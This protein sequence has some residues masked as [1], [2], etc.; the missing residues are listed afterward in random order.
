MKIIN[1]PDGIK[2]TSLI[3]ASNLSYVGT[4]SMIPEGKYKERIKELDGFELYLQGDEEMLA[5]RD[6][7]KREVMYI[8]KFIADLITGRFK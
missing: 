4:F 3:K 2:L 1:V 6:K 7:N 8:R 5:V